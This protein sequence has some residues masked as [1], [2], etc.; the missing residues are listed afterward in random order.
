MFFPQDTSFFT[1]E[2]ELILR[3]CELN[4]F[5][6]RDKRITSQKFGAFAQDTWNNYVIPFWLKTQRFQ[7]IL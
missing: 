7:I 5:T 1:R 6:Y 2:K 4:F 3:S